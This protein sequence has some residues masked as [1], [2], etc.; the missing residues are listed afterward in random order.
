MECILKW[1]CTFLFCLSQFSC[2]NSPN[3]H[4]SPP[5][6][7]DGAPGCA[8]SAIIDGIIHSEPAPKNCSE[9]SGEQRKKCNAQVEA[10]KRSIKKAQEN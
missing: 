9:M 2:S 3:Y 8:V 4:R 1:I 5:D 6:T 10:V 7:C